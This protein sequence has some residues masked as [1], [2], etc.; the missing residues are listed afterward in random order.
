VSNSSQILEYIRQKEGGI[1]LGNSLVNIPIDYLS[2]FARDLWK[3]VS[4]NNIDLSEE[5]YRIIAINRKEIIRGKY[6]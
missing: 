4:K 2:Y 1:R 6:K 3:Y 5:G